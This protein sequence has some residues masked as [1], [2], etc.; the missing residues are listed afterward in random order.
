MELQRKMA[1]GEK[2]P[3]DKVRRTI[4]YLPLYQTRWMFAGDDFHRTI[5]L[6]MPLCTFNIAVPSLLQLC[7][8][9]SCV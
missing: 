8:R 6:E 3:F 2:L 5:E 4:K 7:F 1:A 9:L